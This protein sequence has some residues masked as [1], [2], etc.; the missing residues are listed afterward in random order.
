MK[1]LIVLMLILC[2]VAT[3]AQAVNWSAPIMVA[4]RGTL[5]SGGDGI[6]AENGMVLIAD[7]TPTAAGTWPQVSVNTF[8]Y[9]PGTLG[10]LTPVLVDEKLGGSEAGT[11]GTRVQGVGIDDGVPVIATA[12]WADP[13]TSGKVYT[14]TGVNAYS[15]VTAISGIL[16]YGHAAHREAF[17]LD[18]DDNAYYVYTDLTGTSGQDIV[19]A[20]ASS[21]TSTSWTHTIMSTPA[22][23]TASDATAAKVALDASNNPYVSYLADQNPH[24]PFPFYTDDG[25]GAINTGMNTGTPT[26]RCD[27]EIGADGNPIVAT[28]YGS[29]VTVAFYDGVSAYTTS[30]VIADSPYDI[31]W[32]NTADHI[33]LEIDGQ[34]RPVVLVSSLDNGYLNNAQTEAYLDYYVYENGVWTAEHIVTLPVSAGQSIGA[35]DL[36]FD[37]AG[38][39]FIA[40][41][42]NNG[43]ANRDLY[44]IT[45]IP[46]PATMILLLGGALGMIIRRKK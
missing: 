14:R 27:M 30:L 26:M 11:W 19:L 16:D 36:T 21:S 25:T 39:P 18:A 37:E 9:T 23:P 10:A 7:A 28:Y 12:A 1:K 6:A 46:E 2:F 4:D 40:F 45:A 17:Q 13:S 34:G 3:S 8:S 33:D 44:L 24:Y 20:T 32:L 38:R 29:G 35:P 15:Y 41:N 43:G 42:A 5:N 22:Y 31:G